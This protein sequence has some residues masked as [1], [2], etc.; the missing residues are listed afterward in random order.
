ME[1]ERE[2]MGEVRKR[3]DRVKADGTRKRSIGL[4]RKRGR[5]EV[6]EGRGGM[7]MEERAE[8]RVKKED[9]RRKD[10]RLDYQ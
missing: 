8:E 6:V 10:I 7:H 2:R 4:K 5:K 3:K 1:S 9:R